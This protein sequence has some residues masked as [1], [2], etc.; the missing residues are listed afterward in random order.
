MIVTTKRAGATPLADRPSRAIGWLD[1][2][3][4]LVEAGGCG[5]PLDLY[6][7]QHE[8][9]AAQ[10]LVKNVEAASV[11]RPSRCRR[12]RCR[13]AGSAAA[14]PDS[15]TRAA[16]RPLGQPGWVETKTKAATFL[17]SSSESWPWKGGMPAPPFVTCRTIAS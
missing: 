10:L 17:I 9:L 12:R 15:A 13:S 8:T 5:E 7:V 3:H 11:R 16:G 6:S 1:D 4:L 2:K 14:S